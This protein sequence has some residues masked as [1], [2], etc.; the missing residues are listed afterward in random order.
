MDIQ[1]NDSL[2]YTELY[3]TGEFFVANDMKDD[4]KEVAVLLTVIRSKAYPAVCYDEEL[5]GDHL[6]PKAR[7][8]S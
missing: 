1:N 8:A 4:K 3:T 6:N 7:I 5:L 2:L